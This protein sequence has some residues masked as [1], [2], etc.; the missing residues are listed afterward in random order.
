MNSSGEGR[1]A[2]KGNDSTKERLENCSS[3]G[4]GKEKVQTTLAFDQKEMAV[5]THLMSGI[6]H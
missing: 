4:K 2:L 5:A 3:S 1:T 6:K